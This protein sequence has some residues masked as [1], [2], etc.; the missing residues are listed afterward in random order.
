MSDKP[1]F[2][3]LKT[4]L[5]VF[6]KVCIKDVL[7]FLTLKKNQFHTFVEENTDFSTLKLVMQGFY[8]IQNGTWLPNF[9]DFTIPTM[10]T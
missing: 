7:C 10:G 6:C 2:A 5:F 4:D 9:R 1:K 8:T 3:I